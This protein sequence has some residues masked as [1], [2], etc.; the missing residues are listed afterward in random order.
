VRARIE[1]LCLEFRRYGYRRITWQLRREGWAVGHALVQAIMQRECLQCQVKRSW[2]A[3]TQSQHGLPRY[4][5][6]LPTLTVT[7]VN[8][9][10][11]ADLTYIRLRR[12]FL[13]LAVILDSFSRRVVG[14]ELAATLEAQGCVAALER[15]VAQRR[16]APGWVHHSDQG[17][18]YASAAYV[19]VLTAAQ[20]RI[21]R[22][23]RGNP[24]D[25]AQ[26]ESFMKTLKAEE[27]HLTHYEDEAH[28]RR[29]LAHFL[30][31]VY[32]QR[33]LHSRLDYRPP[34]EFEAALL[35]QATTTFPP[36]AE[37]LF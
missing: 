30:D 11:V 29:C 4:P 15:A 35:A 9:L 2:V 25:N 37:Q 33:R 10:W 16:P 14:W 31:E 20:A 7:G 3:T 1:E 12:Q 28:A 8:Q 24:Y 26:A 22:A 13:Y 17:V 18:Q 32:N 5:N 36:E 34:A 27:V 23:R 21:S 19:S 6:L